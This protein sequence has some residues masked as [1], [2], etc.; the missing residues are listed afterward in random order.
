[1]KKTFSQ[2]L[3]VFWILLSLLVCVAP[4]ARAQ[5]LNKLATELAA[6]IRAVKHDRVTVADF[7]DLDKKP[8]K[9]GKFLTQKLQLALADPKHG[10]SVVDQSQLPQLFDQIEKL[11]E[12]L[13]D[14]ATGKQLG[15]ITGV[16]VV[17]VGTVMVSS[18]SVKLDVKAIDLQTAKL[19]TGESSSISRIGFNPVDK[20]A[21][22]VDGEDSEIASSEN[23]TDS[24][25]SSVQRSAVKSKAPTRIR[26]DQGVTFELNGCSLSGD[27]LVCALTVTSEARDRRL[28]ISS[29]SRAW[30]DSGDE[31]RPFDVVIANSTHGYGYNSKQ[32]LKNVP[33]YMSLTFPQF[34]DDSSMVERLRVVWSEGD[35]ERPL[36]F[37]KIVVDSDL[38][39]SRAAARPSGGSGD[40]SGGKGKGGFLKRVTGS[41][42]NTL[43][44]AAEEVI[45]KKTKKL[46]GDDDEAKEEEEKPPKK[47]KKQ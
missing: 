23:D 40:A 5:D 19:I 6:R 36:D 30:N 9:L 12:G 3:G 15:K 17:I 46:V 43:E 13:L 21:K 44:S 2:G 24:R 37:E 45:E 39:S 42:V 7:V 22:E 20:L 27:A 31:Y 32:I 34:G 28:E 18:M 14:P 38:S 29:D 33:T 41:I 11:N 16:E 25:S 35:G 26:R 4:P 10:L 8:N 47:K 1:V